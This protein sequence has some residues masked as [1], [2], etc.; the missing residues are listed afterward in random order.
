MLYEITANILISTERTPLMGI[1]D[2]RTIRSEQPSCEIADIQKELENERQPR[3]RVELRFMKIERDFLKSREAQTQT[4]MGNNKNTSIPNTV[5]ADM[6]NLEAKRVRVSDAL[7]TSQTQSDRYPEINMLTKIHEIEMSSSP[8]AEN[9]LQ[10][11]THLL[12]R[13]Y[14]QNNY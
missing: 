2:N 7:E 4:N 1:N 9:I 14:S 3:Q 12:V 10:C 6:E 8:Q 5:L 13:T 11:S